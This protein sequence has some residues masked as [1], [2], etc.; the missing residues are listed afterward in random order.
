MIVFN[1]VLFVCIATGQV[2]IYWSI[3]ANS[4]AAADTS[5]QSKDLT[6]AR[7]LIT[8]V[9][10]D[11]LC[12]FPIGLLGV[13]ASAGTR[14]SGEVN[15]AMA[16]VV[17]PVSSVLNPFLYALNILLEH[18][19]RAREERVQA[20]LLSQWEKRNKEMAD[21]KMHVT[22]TEDEAWRMLTGWLSQGVLSYEQVDEQLSQR[23]TN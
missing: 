10:S 12:W 16:I 17:L 11:F 6:I 7:R 19:R 21:D 5:K 14:I 13:L 3:R 9:V 2:F 20:C 22:Y 8:V 1:F 4:M 18:R 15:V 23:D